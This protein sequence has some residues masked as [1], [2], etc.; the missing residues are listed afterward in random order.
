MSNTD[1]TRI[2][3]DLLDSISTST[4]VGSDVQHLL[5]LAELEDTAH[6]RQAVKAL[7]RALASDPDTGVRALFGL[8]RIANAYAE[9]G[10]R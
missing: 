8:V 10:K 2:L 3:P 7:A 9:E 1:P 4:N 6:N 5:H